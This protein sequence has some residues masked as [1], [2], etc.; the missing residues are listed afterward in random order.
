LRWLFRSLAGV[1]ILVL[2]AFWGL[3]YAGVQTWAVDQ[4][5][6]YLNKKTGFTMSVKRVDLDWFD[7]LH[8]K[9][10]S[11]KDLQGRQ[12]LFLGELEVDYQ[13]VTLFS[14]G[15]IRLDEVVLKNG[16]VELLKDD[17]DLN[18]SRLIKAFSKKKKNKDPNKK[19]PRFFIRKASLENMDFHYLRLGQATYEPGQ[20]NYN[21]FGFEKMYGELS[22]FKVAQD[23]VAFY[24]MGLMGNGTQTKM[25]INE[26][27][28]F[29]RFTSREIAFEELLLSLGNS[30][31]RKNLK[32]VYDD[33]ADLSEFTTKV[34]IVADLDRTVLHAQDLAVFAPALKNNYD[35]YRLSGRFR[36]KMANFG[37]YDLDFQFGRNSHLF[38]KVFFRGLPNI[39]ETLMRFDLDNSR[40]RGSDM[41]YYLPAQEF[42][43]FKKFGDIRFNAEFS[44]FFNNFVTNGTFQTDIG[45]IRTDIN[46]ET[47]TGNYAGKLF[48]Q[49]F[50]LGKFIEQEKLVQQI[51]LEGNIEGK[52]LS[53]ETANFNLNGEI[54]R[55]GFNN[56]DYR[57]IRTDGHFEEGLFNGTFTVQDSNLALLVD[58]EI[59][60]AEESFNFW[61]EL[62]TANLYPLNFSKD[63][64]FLKTIL[65]ARFNGLDLNSMAGRLDFLDF[66]MA[67]KGEALALDS[68]GLFTA[69]DADSLRTIQLTSELMEVKAEGM[70]DIR[71]LYRDAL[72]FGRSFANN[73]LL[74]S[75]SQRIAD[76]SESIAEQLQDARP[77]SVQFDAQFH[78]INPILNLLPQKIEVAPNSRFSGTF[79]FN[80]TVNIF[81]Q[82]KSELLVF[83]QY[84]FEQNTFGLFAASNYKGDSLTYEFETEITSKKQKLGAYKTESLYFSGLKVGQSILFSANID[85]AE[86][87]DNARIGGNIGFYPNKMRINLANSNFTFLNKKWEDAGIALAEIT[88]KTVQFTDM[89][90]A[91][92]EQLL[93][94]DGTISQDSTE[95]LSLLLKSFDLNI[96]SRYIG[97]ELKGKASVDAEISNVYRSVKINSDIAVDSIA[98]NKFYLG[99]LLASTK[100]DDARSE[101]ALSATLDRDTIYSINMDGQYR[102]SASKEKQFALTAQLDAAPLYIIEPFLEDLISEVDGIASGTLNVTGSATAPV[103]DGKLAIDAGQ[104]TFNYLGTKYFFDDALEFEEGA[105][106]FNNFLLA[107]DENNYA[108]LNGELSLWKNNDFIFDLEGNMRRF[109]LLDTEPDPDALYYGQAYGTGNISISGNTSDIVVNLQAKT[110]RKTK[111]YIPIEGSEKV[112]EQNYITFVSET[113]TDTT[114]AADQTLED[115]GSLQLNF[116]LELTPDAYCEIIFDKKAGDIIRG[117]VDG[118]MQLEIDTD[119]KFNMYGDVEIVKG[120]YNFTLLNV[121]D[122][123]FNVLPNSHIT[124]TGD[125]YEASLDVKASYTQTASLG[126][127]LQ[128]TTLSNRPELRRRYPVDVLLD[129]EGNLLNPDISFSID[130][131]GYPATVVAAG[132]P[133]SL[134]TEVAAFEE[135]IRND[136]QERN[137]QVFSLIVL[138]KLSPETTF[139]GMSQTAGGSVSELLANQLSYWISQVDENLEIDI[140]M[141][142][143]NAEALNTFRLR[144][145]YNFLDGRLRV[146]REGAFTNQQNEANLS[147][148]FGDIT[149]EYLLT[150]SGQLRLRMYHK[151]NANAFNTGLENNSV[152]GVSIIHSG[153]FDKL[154]GKKKKRK[155]ELEQEKQPKETPTER[156]TTQVE[157]QEAS[158][159]KEDE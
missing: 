73:L 37:I 130:I 74:D 19:P 87:A 30:L 111:I 146:T 115:E 104:F 121:I 24:A 123:R 61:A 49:N 118:K 14:G 145:A 148:V 154:F 131:Q 159:R 40:V 6:E 41:S 92:N 138:K 45:L 72:G 98:L 50:E 129:L 21:N 122:K 34:E 75:L 107:D 120:A 141:N 27:T 132:T 71:E 89:T 5:T 39:D 158:S 84:Q 143:L 10:V 90:F 135:R 56:Y 57:N 47:E 7:R 17:E 79:G 137:R 77:Y 67:Y 97:K 95:T 68:L 1:L 91:S 112:E 108:Y 35:R 101:L 82:G 3:Q 102:P 60:F 65:D 70:Y 113:L 126:P 23:T 4:A 52:G 64:I 155:K 142:G 96:L 33:R 80:G 43:Q 81:C 134:E 156:P 150:P 42:K 59:N 109:K 88:G 128:D 139:S 136:E 151:S 103:I 147:S 16:S 51:D 22:N 53:V 78:N 20:F 31:L 8:L 9:Q 15:D 119:G 36:G 44:G 62:D 133:I 157:K 46:L 2:L 100:W 106:V 13:L 76:Y 26:L 94:L 144:L 114:A 29:F 117:N 18:F 127:I 125:P 99:D 58:G 11:I 66:F 140:D 149:V 110:E 86:S 28:T 55:L 93:K 105:L 85:H 48:T 25:P 153:S 63:T 124:W 38:G 116:D 54:S 152:G 32:F 12:M 69:K 83:E